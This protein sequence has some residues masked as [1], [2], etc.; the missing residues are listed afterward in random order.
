MDEQASRFFRWRTI[1]G[2]PIQL[3]NRT[4]VPL[5]RTIS[6]ALGPRAGPGGAGFTWTRPVAVEVTEGSNTRRI[7]IR[8]AGLWTVLALTSVA[9]LPILLHR[10][11]RWQRREA[12]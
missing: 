3:R 12:E 2:E 9:I 8:D 11:G 7:P 1:Q 10:M 5:A 6:L 4:L